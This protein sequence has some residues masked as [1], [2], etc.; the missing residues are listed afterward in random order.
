MLRV[1]CYVRG[2][3]ALWR[4][5]TRA[6][7]LRESVKSWEV[8]LGFMCVGRG[9]VEVEVE[10]EADVDV[11]YQFVPTLLLL[12]FYDIEVLRYYVEFDIHCFAGLR[13][14][15]IKGDSSGSSRYAT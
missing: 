12:R 7:W 6:G 1:A 2:S 5:R 11:R 8:E 3:I 13:R 10:V 4:L 14:K 15:S 9:N